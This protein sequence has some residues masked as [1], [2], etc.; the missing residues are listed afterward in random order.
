M[1]SNTVLLISLVFML[2]SS[3]AIAQEESIKL[4]NGE[5]VVVIQSARTAT[6]Y[7]NGALKDIDGKLVLTRDVVFDGK[8]I[9]KRQN[10]QCALLTEMLLGFDDVK[11]GDIHVQIPRASSALTAASCSA[12]L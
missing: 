10:G 11:V 9:V 6:V 12:S 8:S 1:K 4:S 5:S 7:V 3:P 2:D